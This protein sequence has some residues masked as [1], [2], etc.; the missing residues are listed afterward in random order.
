MADAIVRTGL[1]DAGYVFVNL[2]DAWLT[3]SRDRI[4][5]LQG[6]PALPERNEVAGRRDAQP[7][8]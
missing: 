7:G 4:G 5:N 1:R 6:D 3:P 8:P 2:D